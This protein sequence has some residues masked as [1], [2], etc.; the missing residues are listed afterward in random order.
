MSL[1]W[2]GVVPFLAYATAFLLLPAANV[3]VGA[4]QFAGLSIGRRGLVH[5]FRGECGR[6][7]HGRG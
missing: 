2:L 1:A 6:G 7:C 5:G 3:L 4:F